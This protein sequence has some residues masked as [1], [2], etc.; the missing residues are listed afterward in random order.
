MKKTDK[1]RYKE[2]K[3]KLKKGDITQEEF[4]ELDILESINHNDKMSKLNA[5]ILISAAVAAVANVILLLF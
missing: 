5:A 3:A 2:L 1:L 4:K